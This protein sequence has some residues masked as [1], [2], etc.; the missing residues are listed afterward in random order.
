[1]LWLG[2]S[3]LWGILDVICLL[4]SQGKE[5][6]A[7]NKETQSQ[8]LAANVA[9]VNEELQGMIDSLHTGG[10]PLCSKVGLLDA[11]N[12]CSQGHQDQSNNINIAGCFPLQLLLA[13]LAAS[14]TVS[15]IAVAGFAG[16]VGVAVVASQ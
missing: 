7:D 8:T 15:N 11:V 12:T 10:Q 3:E 1:M 6:I 2:S 14:L 4:F 16:G 13:R 5:F 9:N